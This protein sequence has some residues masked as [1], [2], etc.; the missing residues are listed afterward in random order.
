MHICVGRGA[1]RR[2]AVLLAWSLIALSASGA[3]F[4]VEIALDPAKIDAARDAACVTPGGTSCGGGGGGTLRI[5]DDSARRRKIAD[6]AMKE[7][8]LE[9]PEEEVGVREEWEKGTGVGVKY[10]TGRRPRGRPTA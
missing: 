5:V 7:L 10:D 6:D 3:V 2:W 8:L 1:P 9:T 4:E